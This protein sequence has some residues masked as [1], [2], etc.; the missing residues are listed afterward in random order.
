M[1]HKWPYKDP[2]EVLDYTHDWTPRMT[3]GD[4]FA[5]LPT[6]TVVTGDVVVDTVTASG[7]LQ[8][9]WL[10]GGTADTAVKLTL[11]VTTTGGRTFEE[12]VRMRVENRS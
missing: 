8:T 10:S 7:F 4:A 1:A 9:V 2:D 11:R 6:C 12:T 5:G 3:E